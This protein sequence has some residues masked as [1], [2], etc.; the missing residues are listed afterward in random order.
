MPR[1]RIE[2]TIAPRNEALI[3]SEASRA[4]DAHEGNGNIGMRM[5]ITD[6][7]REVTTLELPPSAVTLI[8]EM[9]REMASG[10]ALA[11]VADDAEIH[12]QAGR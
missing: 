8:R 6:A 4:L 9:L 2:R 11:L 12:H 10:R 1:T 3:A 7:G 5:Q